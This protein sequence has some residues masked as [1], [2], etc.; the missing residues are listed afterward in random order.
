MRLLLVGDSPPAMPLLL[1]LFAGSEP[2]VTRCADS[3]QAIAELHD[4]GGRYDWVILESRGSLNEE[5]EI[6]AAVEALG[7]PLPVGYLDAAGGD[8]PALSLIGATEK[9][10]DGSQFL[11]CALSRPGAIQIAYRNHGE[12]EIILEYQAHCK[13][14]EE[15]AAPVLKIRRPAADSLQRPQLRKYPGGLLEG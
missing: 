11:R 7:L 8:K 6:V 15:S 4:S 9:S 14:G 10:P 2:S 5:G 3:S 12:E 1:A 13:T